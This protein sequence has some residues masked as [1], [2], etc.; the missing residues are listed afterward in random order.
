MSNRFSSMRPY[1]R[2]IPYGLGLFL[3]I[4]S[5]ATL[6]RELQQYSPR[7][8]RQS[9]AAIPNFFLGG[10]I[11]LTLLNVLTFTGY[12]TLAARYVRQPLPYRK[13][14][15]AAIVSIT[16]S[17]SV[18]FALLSGSAIRYRLY[19]AWG[20]S[21]ADIAHII[22]FCNLGFWLGLFAV[23]SAVFLLDPVAMPTLLNLP[24]ESVQPLGWMFLAIVI[25]YLLW[26]LLRREDL[27]IGPLEVPHLPLP[28]ALAQIGV[29]ALDWVLA[30]AVLY[31]LLPSSVPL[32]YPGFFGVY[33]L[34]Q[35]AGVVSNVPGGLGVFETVILLLL[36]PLV[37]SSTVFGAL[38]AYRGIYYLAPFFMSVAVLVL[39]ELTQRRR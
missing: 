24:F 31:A 7:E 25:S 2:F 4:I 22:A 27:H 5:I 30:A 12:D 17:N 14:A 23:G 3:F 1:A 26:S 33:L 36:S 37:P 28:L 13:T 19:S 38:I 16:I 9:L 10:A 34:G 11:A 29:A 21:A 18:G 35:I 39:Y 15:L 6:H 8:I 32:A 20:V